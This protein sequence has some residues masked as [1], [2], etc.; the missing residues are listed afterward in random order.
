MNTQTASNRRL[1]SSFVVAAVL[2]LLANLI[3]VSNYVPQARH[4]DRAAVDPKNVDHPVQK[5]AKS[6]SYWVAK[7]YI[8]QNRAPDVVLFGSSQM[9]SAI[10]CADA[11][12]RE[13]L[14]DTVTHKELWSLESELTKQLSGR[15]VRV[16]NASIPGCM[17]SDVDLMSKVLFRDS[18][19]KPKVVVLGIAPRDFLDNTLTSPSGTEPWHFFS[20]F[21]PTYEWPA[22]AFPDFFAN[23]DWQVNQHT[24]R[25]L[26][27]LAQAL[28]G[29]THVDEQQ[30]LEGKKSD[31]PLAAVLGTLGEVKAGQWIVP[32]N[33]PPMW[34]DNSA[35]YKNRFR[36]SRHP[37]Y[38]TERQFFKAF[39]A[40][41]KKEEIQ[42]IVV[43]M[44]SLPV[45]RALLPD[46]FWARFHNDM[47]TACG[48]NTAVYLPLYSD[49]EFEIADYLDTVH[50]DATGGLKLFA[51][52]ASV[53]AQDKDI[54]VAL[55]K[56]RGEF[57][58]KPGELEKQQTR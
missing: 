38:K 22:Q 42:V 11:Q 46:R 17:I 56:R 31:T 34:K 54:K 52:I 50:L 36:D 7:G 5:Q 6:W 21:V 49:P 58:A 47:A 16:F 2:F 20:Q 29:T 8:E 27:P 14:V 1:L 4:L 51:R 9:G 44:P 40:R 39:L 24:M 32:A 26:A 25:E 28:L 48:E 45:N 43:G 41:M 30:A 33:I 18:G 53:M 37:I 10:A 23:L 13:S 15:P 57:A 35:E 55:E 19:M 3:L 12:L